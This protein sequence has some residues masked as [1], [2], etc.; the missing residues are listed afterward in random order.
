[1]ADLAAL[2]AADF[3]PLVGDAFDIAGTSPSVRLVL[4]SVD[5]GDRAF[6]RRRSFS[7]VFIGPEAP[8][9]AQGVWPL[10]HQAFDR[11]E[12]FL[13]PIGPGSNGPRYEAVFT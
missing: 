10:A 6:R 2:T 8:L 11:L 7:L 4:G 5:Q 3:D 9:L 1:M 13:V 12:I